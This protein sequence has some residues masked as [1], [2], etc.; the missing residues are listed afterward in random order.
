MSFLL[1]SI[2]ISPLSRESPTCVCSM[3]IDCENVYSVLLTSVWVQKQWGRSTLKTSGAKWTGPSGATEYLS[4]PA[5]G[6][7]A[8]NRTAWAECWSTANCTLSLSNSLFCSLLMMF[9]KW[10]SAA[11][12][13]LNVPGEEWCHWWVLLRE[14]M[15]THLYLTLM[16]TRNWSIKPVVASQMMLYTHLY[17]M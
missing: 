16:L 14:R 4:M 1:L 8:G 12:G 17:T 2:L 3:P 15:R 9:R 6:A 11:V 13:P 7:G 10:H 5:E